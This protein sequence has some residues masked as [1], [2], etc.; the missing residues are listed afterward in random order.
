ML[1]AL[2]IA[3]IVAL[4]GTLGFLAA[5]PSRFVR[6]RMKF[7]IWLL[8]ACAALEVAVA[9]SLGE[10]V[11]LSS[12]ARLLFVLAVINFGIAL[13]VNP[14][15]EDRPSDRFPAIVQ[16]VSIIGLFMVVATVL[17]GEQLLTTS[18]VGAVVVGFALQ[19]TLGNLFAGLAIQIEKPFRV[20]HWIAVDNREGQ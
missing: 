1:S 4:A 15:R 16:D 14:W 3:A 13:L 6:G 11:L 8:L 17:L 9:G 20:G 5:L 10:V 7:S 19:D 2:F 18:A 12:I